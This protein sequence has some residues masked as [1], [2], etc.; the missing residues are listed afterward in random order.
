MLR[1]LS[2]SALLRRLPLAS[3]AVLAALL[4]AGSARA[5]DTPRTGRMWTYGGFTTAF[6]PHVSATALG[7]YRVEYARSGEVDPK[8]LYLVELF[9]GP[10]Y[11]GK[12][13][14]HLTLKGSLWYYYVGFPALAA[15][16]YYR[17]HNV[18]VIPSAEYRA[19]RWSVYDRVILHNTVYASVYPTA[20]ERAGYGLVLRELLQVRYAI[21]EKIGLLLSDEPF[22]G[23]SEDGDAPVNNGPGYWEKGLRV[24]R[25]YTGFDFKLTP[26]FTLTPLYV[27]EQTFTDGKVSER[28]N[29]AFVT[30]SYLLKL[31]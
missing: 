31:F 1:P 2:T 17:Q 11:T 6:T 26:E 5:A 9:L 24:N 8:R 27:H 7:G 19:G 15:D 30:M 21:T 25:V 29:Y 22:I 16:R 23:L 28:G 20:Q 3:L 10:T 18:E 14:D 4:I 12:V 13:G